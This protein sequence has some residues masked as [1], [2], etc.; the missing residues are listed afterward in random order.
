MHDVVDACRNPCDCLKY[1]QEIDNIIENMVG[2]ETSPE[3]SL[4]FFD[5]S[6]KHLKAFL[7]FDQ[8]NKKY[9]AEI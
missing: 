2:Q 8:I 4:K 5:I 9:S 3:E 1:L 6:I 7:L